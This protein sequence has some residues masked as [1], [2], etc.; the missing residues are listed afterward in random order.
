MA[1][2]SDDFPFSTDVTSSSC[3]MPGPSIST[4]ITNTLWY[5]FEKNTLYLTHTHTHTANYT[6]KL[7]CDQNKIWEKAMAV[8]HHWF[9]KVS[10]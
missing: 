4:E 5:Y 8:T 9:F 3:S 1:T 2:E 7:S 10:E 6:L